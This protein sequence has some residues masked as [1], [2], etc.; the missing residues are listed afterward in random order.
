MTTTTD[1]P[2]LREL[3]KQREKIRTA[4]EA[5]EARARIPAAA[6]AAAAIHEASHA[7]AA[8][9]AGGRITDLALTPHDPDHMG[10]CTYDG[11][12]S[13]AAE[14]QITF[15]GAVG[16]ARWTYGKMPSIREVRSVLDGHCAADG[17]GDLDKLTASGE[18]LPFEV[19]R[20]IE[21]TWPAIQTIARH[22]VAHDHADH[23][24]VCA[25]LGV[26]E[27]DS[28]LSAQASSI[29]AGFTPTP[30]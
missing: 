17:T 20:L 8:V 28:H 19:G 12:L 4:R 5:N 21:T 24:T 23:A 6:I 2:F 30:H 9:L 27:T 22:L 7:V 1:T 18:P 25:A 26:P 10:R 11:Q 3:T 15:A 13:A 14:A 16:E 29:R